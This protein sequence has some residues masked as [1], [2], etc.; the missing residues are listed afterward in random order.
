MQQKAGHGLIYSALNG[1]AIVINRHAQHFQRMQN[2]QAH[3]HLLQG[4]TR[5]TAHESAVRKVMLKARD[6]YASMAMHKVEMAVL[7]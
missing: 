2:I 4:A 7:E 3:N 5:Y 1:A 6:L